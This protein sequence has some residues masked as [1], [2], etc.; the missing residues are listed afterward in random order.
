MNQVTGG[1][2]S[3]LIHDVNVNVGGSINVTG[4]ISEGNL[5]T[6]ANQLA[7]KYAEETVEKVGQSI[8]YGKLRTHVQEANGKR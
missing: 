6:F 5:K 4:D 8:R 1:G 2:E 3:R 7:K